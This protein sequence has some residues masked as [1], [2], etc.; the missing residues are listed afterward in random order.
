M[1]QMRGGHNVP[2]LKGMSSIATAED[3]PVS[4]LPEMMEQGENSFHQC[5]AIPYLGNFIT[6][7]LLDPCKANESVQRH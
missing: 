1:R 6:S 4:Y 3:V 7:Y 5:Y 2:G